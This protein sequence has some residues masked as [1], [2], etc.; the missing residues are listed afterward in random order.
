MRKVSK[1]AVSLARATIEM[2]T[3]L[4]NAYKLCTENLKGGNNLD[5]HKRTVENREAFIYVRC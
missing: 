2:V 4:T 5:T 3:T 1:L